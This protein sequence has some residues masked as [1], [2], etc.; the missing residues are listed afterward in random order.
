[1]ARGDVAISP[2]MG[3]EAQPE[4]A[5]ESAARTV[6]GGRC[7]SLRGLEWCSLP[8]RTMAGTG[9]ISSAHI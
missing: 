4:T 8:V 3:V 5:R 2:D 9:T 7:A 6:K 1:M